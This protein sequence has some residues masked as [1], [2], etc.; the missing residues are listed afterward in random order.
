MTDAERKASE[1]ERL[2]AEIA[3]YCEQV[4]QEAYE[5]LLRETDHDKI[6]EGQRFILASRKFRAAFETAVT[7]GKQAARKAPAV[8]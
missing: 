3:P 5:A 2:L 6:I 7:L 1:A 4:E 8:A